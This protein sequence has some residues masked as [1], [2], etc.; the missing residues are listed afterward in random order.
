MHAHPGWEEKSYAYHG[1]L[2]SYFSHFLFSIVI[3]LLFTILVGL[4]WVFHDTGSGLNFCPKFSTDDTV[5]V[6]LNFETG[7][8]FFTLNGKFLG[9]GYHALSTD[10]KWYPTVG[11]QSP[12]EKIKVNFGDSPFLFDFEA[13]SLAHF[14]PY[15]SRLRSILTL[16]ALFQP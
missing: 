8:V 13:R 14:C 5:G 7:E 11:L 2:G 1:D 16:D 6:G 10:V 12:G 9:V 3:G 4:G 15:P